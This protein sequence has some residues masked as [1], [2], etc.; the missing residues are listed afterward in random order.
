MFFSTFHNSYSQHIAEQ[1]KWTN[2]KQFSNQYLLKHMTTTQ[3]I[4][5]L[6]YTPNELTHLLW[7]IAQ[8][9]LR[10]APALPQPLR[11]QAVRIM[12]V[13]LSLVQEQN[14][15]CF[16]IGIQLVVADQKRAV[17]APAVLCLLSL[18][19]SLSRLGAPVG[20]TPLLGILSSDLTS[21]APA[22]PRLQLHLVFENVKST[23]DST[24]RRRLTPVD[25]LPSSLNHSCFECTCIVVIAYG[26][27][28]LSELGAR[29]L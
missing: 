9:P 19:L 24:C 17:T 27:R 20:V 29:N 8:W 25:C 22:A 12:D 3:H 6:L 16:W 7:L 11:R 26:Y 10:K 23:K 13:W 14:L 21:M 2:I 15:L 4:N 5:L 1:V 28:L 18:S